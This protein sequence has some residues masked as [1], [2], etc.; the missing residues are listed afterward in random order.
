MDLTGENL[1]GDEPVK[2]EGATFRA[3][4]PATGA[5]LEPP[6]READ[7]P[8]VDRAL[9]GTQAVFPAFAA[10]PPEV[11][12]GFLRGIA[13]E[14]EA[15][16]QDL[17][18]RA[19][20]ESA[21]PPARLESERART[22]S[23]LRLFASLLDEG[24]W[25]EA[26]IDPGDPARAPVPRPDIRRMLV[27]LG[28]VAVFAASNFPFAFS[29]AGGDTAA[30]LAAG[31]PVVCKAHPAHPGTSELAARAVGR[32]ARGARLEPHIFSLVHGWSHEPGLALARHP[33]TRA[34]A[35][36]G[37]RKGG[38]AL[39]DEAAARPVPIPV[40]AEMGSVNPVFLLPAALA[41]RCDAIA[42]GL[43]QSI[44]LGVGQYCTNPGVVVGVRGEG[45]DRLRRGLAERLGAMAPGA[46]LHARL[47]EAY[48]AGLERARGRGALVLT[49]PATPPTA[50]RAGAA[51][52]GTYAARFTSDAEWQEEIFGPASLVVEARNVAE[53][54]RV[55]ES[56]EGQLTASIHGTPEEL[57]TH[58]ALVDV[59]RRK[60]GRLIFNGYPTG[61]EVGH[62]MQHGGPYPATTDPRS[63]SVGTASIAR[64][65]RPV[66]YQDFPD[67]AL[68]AALRN[69]NVLGIW[70]RVNGELTK[71]DVRP[72]A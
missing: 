60:A 57:A 30:A 31:C 71:D 18:D 12:A 21:L 27:P 59:L 17:L 2:G 68:P 14:I 10:T 15:L 25:V 4:N 26:R 52:L 50:A 13:E 47:G 24:S 11:R 53:L 44:T 29:V 23:Q 7:G 54:T 43:A 70:R 55:A 38:R 35:F 67:P 6:F 34:V 9:R 8:T 72:A 5:E 40:Y 36:T 62:A 1:V 63:T 19:H 56:L 65:L 69:R 45:L 48:A 42:E 41:E 51:L 46:M 64:F 61:V 32:A 37:S 16:G 49:V 28:P 20:A 58:A 3:V 66:C 22:V 39:L 33:L